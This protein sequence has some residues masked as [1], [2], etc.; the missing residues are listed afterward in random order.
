MGKE[1]VVENETEQLKEKRKKVIEAV[2]NVCK[3]ISNSYLKDISL[4]FRYNQ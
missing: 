2:E 4:V 3:E 1:K